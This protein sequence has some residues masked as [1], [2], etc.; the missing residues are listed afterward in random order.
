VSL[1][2]GVP[3]LLYHSPS[4]GPEYIKRFLLSGTVTLIRDSTSK[5]IVGFWT[6]PLAITAKAEDVDTA[7][8]RGC[9][10]MLDAPPQKDGS[11]LKPAVP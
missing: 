3:S 4:L 2:A 11:A 6:Y 5:L 1:A 9:L 7:K 10:W 8:I